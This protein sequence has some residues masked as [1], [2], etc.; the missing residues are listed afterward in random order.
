MS[1]EQ[2]YDNQWVY[3]LRDGLRSCDGSL[4]QIEQILATTRK[5]LSQ[6]S[7]QEVSDCMAQNQQV[8]AEVIASYQQLITQI[9]RQKKEV[10]QEIQQVQ[11]STSIVHSYVQREEAASF[12][13]LDL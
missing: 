3:Q 5:K 4:D 7:A 8:I 6:V 11:K 12:I 13:D 1:V 2:T 9:N 10:L